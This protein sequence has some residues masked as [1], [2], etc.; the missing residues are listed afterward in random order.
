MVIITKV[1]VIN[2]NVHH[3]LIL[4]Y[5]YAWLYFDTRMQQFSHYKNGVYVPFSVRLPIWNPYDTTFLEI[6]ISARLTN[7][8]LSQGHLNNDGPALF[9]QN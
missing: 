8:L 4:Q 7:W 9:G 2:E 1:F 6:P 3:S 5:L